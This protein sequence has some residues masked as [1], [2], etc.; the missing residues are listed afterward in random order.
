MVKLEDISH[1]HHYVTEKTQGKYH[2]VYGPYPTPVLSIKSGDTVTCET[3][4]AF[5]GQIKTESDVP[6][7]ILNFP[8]LNPQNGPIF[9]ESA[10]KGDTLCVEILKISPRGEQPRGT[11]LIMPQFGGL[12]STKE[13]A[14]LQKDLPERVRK[15]IVTEEKGTIWSDKIT[16]PY[17]PFIGSI[18]V[19]P[20]IEAVSALQPDYWGGNMDLPDVRPGNI[21][22]FP[23]NAPGALLY[24]GDCHATQGDGELSGV[25]L[26]H[27]THTTVRVHLV[28]D[29]KISGP[30]IESENFIM[31]VGSARPLEDA[32]RMAYRDLIE[33][34]ATDF[35]FDRIDAYMLLS[36]C[37][38][39][40]LG[41]MVDPKY[42]VAASIKKSYL[43]GE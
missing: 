17:E 26:E 31:S 20:E 41:N 12:V 38:R 42:T 15:L 16:I 32:T 19:S 1:T 2:Y 7:E 18:G 35:G 23:V 43:F 6:S 9:V 22:Y 29:W 24:L 10:E 28:K 13:T 11:T 40:R 39:V 27:P 5:E 33:W 37:G 36:Q 25:A 8:Y 14:S 4:D 34:M 21:I 30:R 3:H